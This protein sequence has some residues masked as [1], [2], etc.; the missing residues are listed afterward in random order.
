MP[1]RGEV[2][3]WPHGSLRPVETDLHEASGRKRSRPAPTPALAGCGP[4]SIPE[5]GKR[6]RFRSDLA[7]RAME[8]PAQAVSTTSL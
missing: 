3:D 7:H 2:R 4:E 6:E 1:S 8:Q 5:P